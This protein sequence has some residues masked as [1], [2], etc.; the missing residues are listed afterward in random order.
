M[1]KLL[2]VSIFAI[3]MAVLSHQHSGYD[4]INGEYRRKERLF[5]AALSVAL[6]AMVGLRTYYNDTSTYLLAYQQLREFPERYQNLD[7]LKIGSNPGFVFVQSILLQLN[8][9]DQTFLM[10]FSIFTVGTTLWFY[11]KY[12]CNLWLSILMFLSISGYAFHMA[13]IKQCTAMAFCLIATDRAINKKYIMFVVLVLLGSLFHPYALMY[14]IVPFLF[15]RPW[16]KSTLFMIAIF[17]AVGFG[18]ESLIGTLLNVTDMLGENYNA[19]SFVGEGVNPFRLLVLL[20]P[21]VLALI[22]KDQIAENEEKD[23]HLITNL[24]MLNAEIMF[25][26]LFGTANYFARLANYFVPFQ[27][28]AIPW[29]LKLFDQRGR[30]TM[31][32]LVVLGYGLFFVYSQL[33]HESFDASYYGVTL[34]AYL[35]ELLEGVLY[36]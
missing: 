6:I 27:A 4:P 22:L 25:V 3:F 33:I 12:S 7:W 20:V 10:V 26:A 11:H 1:K 13:A 29:L 34:W 16:S 28:L 2:P 32:L 8:A 24:A 30:R 15:F 5:Y 14:L 19:T 36:K 17:A 23:Q 31:M 18:M 21:A 35:S 9:S